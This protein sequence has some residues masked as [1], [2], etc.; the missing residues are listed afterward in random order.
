MRRSQQ[1]HR[2]ISLSDL[3]HSSSAGWAFPRQGHRN[4]YHVMA[5]LNGEN[6]LCLVSA[7]GTTEFGF[8]SEADVFFPHCGERFKVYGI[9][10]T[11]DERNGDDHSHSTTPLM[12][13]TMC[14]MIS[15]VDALIPVASVRIVRRRLTLASIW[16]RRNS[17]PCSPLVSSAYSSI[18]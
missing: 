10:N 2:L 7:A 6:G 12:V 11:Q 3:P 1:D 9:S 14:M 13:C 4:P 18:A 17:A 15:L 8:V 16:M 5:S